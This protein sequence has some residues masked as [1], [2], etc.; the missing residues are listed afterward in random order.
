MDRLEGLTHEYARAVARAVTL[1]PGYFV[2]FR[3][4]TQQGLKMPCAGVGQAFNRC[5]SGRTSCMT[6]M[7]DPEVLVLAFDNHRPVL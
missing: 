2:F 7:T 4:T 5:V 6:Y 3:E 1:R